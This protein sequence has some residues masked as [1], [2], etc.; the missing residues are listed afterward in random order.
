MARLLRAMARLDAHWTG[1]LIGAAC[2]F[3]LL[4]MGLFIGHG[5]G[6]K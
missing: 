1:D 6:L 3:A 4:F 5:L 2:L